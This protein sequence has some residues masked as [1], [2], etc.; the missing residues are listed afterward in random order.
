MKVAPL[1]LSIFVVI[2]VSI[3]MLVSGLLFYKN[4]IGVLGAWNQSSKMSVFLKVDTTAEDK[5]RIVLF[6]KETS[7][8][9]NV[10][11]IDRSQAGTA[12]RNSLKEFSSGLMTDDEMIDLIPETLEVDLKSSTGLNQR[13][14][15]FADIAAGLRQHAQVEEV[16]YSASWLRKF[17]LLDNIFRTTGFMVFLI[18]LSSISYL[19]ALMVRVYIEDSK[20]EIEIYSLLGVTRW[21]VYKLFLKDVFIFLTASLVTSFALLFL[22]FQIIK[23]KF[24][25][26]GLSVMITENLRFLSF[27]EVLFVTAAL[28]VFIYLNSFLTIQT[29]VTKLNQLSND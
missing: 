17:E 20:Q 28:F 11:L 13:E 25:T 29:A 16:S 14:A 4:L 18:V 3:L 8:V 26:S 10:T 7:T 5:E 6:L 15:V 24:A 19:V 2:T 9:E 22:S 27:S 23:T 21:S 1:K 12:F